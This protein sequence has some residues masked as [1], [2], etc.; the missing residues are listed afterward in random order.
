MTYEQGW[1]HEYS[2]NG[3]H[4]LVMKT[5]DG[6]IILGEWAG[7]AFIAELHFVGKWFYCTTPY[8]SAQFKSDRVFKIDYPFNTNVVQSED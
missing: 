6:K 3:A 8:Y 7:Y 2:S 4:R 1:N 5:D